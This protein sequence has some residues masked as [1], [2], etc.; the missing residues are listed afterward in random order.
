VFI[1]F[2][3]LDRCLA[4]LTFH[5]QL[6]VDL[7]ERSLDRSDLR[8]A[9]APT[10]ALVLL[11]DPILDAR[12]AEHVTTMTTVLRVPGDHGADDAIEVVGG[13]VDETFLIEAEIHSK[14]VEIYIMYF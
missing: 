6:G 4:M 2:Q 9:L 13:Q 8:V 10:G 1:D 12:R 7:P 11:L 14:F 3:H 5:F